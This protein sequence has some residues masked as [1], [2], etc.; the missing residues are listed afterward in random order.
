MN[1]SLFNLLKMN[2]IEILIL[3]ISCGLFGLFAL[4]NGQDNNFDLQNYH[5]YNGFAF[6]GDRLNIDVS[7]AGFQ[8]YFNPILDSLEFILLS[9]MSP[10]TFTFIIGAFSGLSVVAVYKVLT[11]L[12]TDYY[13]SKITMLISIIGSILAVTGSMNLTQV[14]TLFNENI[15]AVFIIYAIYYL[16]K[17]IKYSDNYSLYL[18]G[19]IFGLSLVIKLTAITFVLSAIIVIILKYYKTNL[20]LILIFIFNIIVVYLIVSCS[21]L[22]LMYE[23]F[24]NP[25]YPVLSKYFDAQT[26]LSIHDVNFYPKD[27]YHWFF[28]PF[29]IAFTNTLTCEVPFK[30]TRFLMFFISL[31]FFTYFTLIRR[32]QKIVSNTQLFNYSIIFSIVSYLFWLFIFS[33]Q[34]YSII[35]EFIFSI[36]VVTMISSYNIRSNYKTVIITIIS[37]GAFFS[38]QYGNFGHVQD[39]SKTVFYTPMNIKSSLVVFNQAPSAYLSASLGSSNTYI[40]A[41]ISKFPVALPANYKGLLKRG[42]LVRK[43]DNNESLIYIVNKT[44][45]SDLRWLESYGLKINPEMCFSSYSYNNEI[46]CAIVGNNYKSEL[47]IYDYDAIHLPHGKNV[48]ESGDFLI[49][50]GNKSYVSFGPYIELPRGYYDVKYELSTISKSN[51]LENNYVEAFNSTKGIVM[52]RKLIT[53]IGDSVIIRFH[54]D[55]PKDVWEFRVFN[56]SGILVLKKISITKIIK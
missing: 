3:V 51:A 50:D 1:K 18:S 24:N 44:T 22:I 52:Q 15:N 34:R 40:G 53:M 55:N 5:I 41:P 20:K 37:L 27:I 14:G 36:L 13:N 39:F 56:G 30:E 49:S 43:F 48:M 8:S 19:G 54:V 38:S 28:L 26:A 21:W 31:I 11:L 10:R 2:C 33:I 29:Y 7:P 6:I 35:L 4:H 42:E 12:I 45:D 32:N 9:N 17:G 25:F 46:I 16:L 47:T 23:N